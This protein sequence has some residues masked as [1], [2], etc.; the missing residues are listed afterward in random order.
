MV[1]AKANKEKNEET[2]RNAAKL[3]AKHKRTTKNLKTKLYN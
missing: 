1:K 2:Q 3:K